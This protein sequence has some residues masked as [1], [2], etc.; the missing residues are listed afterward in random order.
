MGPGN[1]CNVG[2]MPGAAKFPT[3]SLQ[4]QVIKSE[5]AKDKNIKVSIAPDG[6]YA[7]PGGYK[8]MTTYLQ[9]HPT[10]TSCTPTATR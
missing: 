10:S 2:V 6:G 4:F 7:R 9:S 8:S 5:L 1:P 3:D